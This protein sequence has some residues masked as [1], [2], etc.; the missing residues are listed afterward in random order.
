MISILHVTLVVLGTAAYLGLA[1]LGWG[2]FA[3]FFAHPALTALTAALFLMSV[4]S[5][6]AGGNMSSGVR[7]DRGKRWILS[8]FTVFGLLNGFLPA[9]TD[10]MTFWTL[11]G[12]AL[13]WLGVGLFAVGGVLRLWPL[14]V[15]GDRFSGLV[16]IQ[17]RHTLVTSG[18]Y[19]VIRNPSYLGV[20]LFLPGW[21]LAFRSGVGV[22]LTALILLPLLARIRAEDRSLHTQFGA[23][24]EAYRARTWRLLPGIY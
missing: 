5:L 16:A 20:L 19:D 3:E 7:E 17:P 21:G 8:A 15:L 23:E 24:Y 10:R 13:R 4:A 18:I 11:D 14:F 12:D 9:W 6:F 1:V 22:V 2:G